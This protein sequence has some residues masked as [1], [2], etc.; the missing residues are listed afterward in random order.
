MRGFIV[1]FFCLVSSVCLGQVKILKL[2]A[3]GD[4]DFS[5]IRDGDTLQIM[6]AFNFPSDTLKISKPISLNKIVIQKSMLMAI[7]FKGIANFSTVTFINSR[8]FNNLVFENSVRFNSSKFNSELM[9][10]RVNFQK[11][12]SFSATEF[13]GNTSFILNQFNFYADFSGVNGEGQL[14]FSESQMPN[15]INFS[16]IKNLKADFRD[17][18]VDSLKTRKISFLNWIDADDSLSRVRQFKF[19]HQISKC[20]IDLKRTDLANI[21]LPY[22]HFWADT[23]GYSY[24][25]KT[26]LYEKLIKKCKEEGMDESVIGWSTE[27]K[28]IENLHNFPTIGYFLN[29]FQGIFWNYG[30]TKSLILLWILGAFLLFNLLNFFIYPE[31]IRVY[32]NPKLGLKLIAKPLTQDAE[33]V[34]E[35]LKKS[36]ATR[37]RYMLHY[38]GMIFFGIKLEHT[39]MSFKN[40]RWV[41]I[42]YL[43][44]VTGIILLGFALNFVVS[45]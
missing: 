8:N 2:P 44:F 9:F 41:A 40:L 32:F 19:S 30:Y 35:I 23:T 22:N 10:H 37:L 25:G 17:V 20:I 45:K 15:V 31:L 26:S 16:N 36:P 18:F 5:K 27:L 21:I 11:D 13:H 28:K 4:Y 24:E 6:R 38:T 14:F 39:D 7:T 29:W 12:V 1:V 33:A 34:I 42:L 43:Q 3:K